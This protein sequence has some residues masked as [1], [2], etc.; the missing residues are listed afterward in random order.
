MKISG[1]TF[2]K[3]GNILGYPFRESILS[4]LPLV[5][6]FIVNVGESE[7]DT[8]E[9]VLA[10]Q[11]EHPKIK[12]LTSSWCE[13]MISKGYVYGQQKMIAQFQCSG[14][15]A[16]YLEADE[17]LHEEDLERIKS[18]MEAYLNDPEVEAL[19]FSY[20]HFYGNAHTYASSPAWYRSEV[21]A[22]KT[23]VRSYAPDGLFW[24]VLDESNKKGRYPQAVLINATIYH[25][26]WVRSE[27][28]M[29]LKHSKVAKYWKHR[30]NT[31]HY[32]EIDSQVLHLFNGTHPQ[33]AHK[34][35]EENTDHFSVHQL[36]EANPRHKLT[37]REKRHRILMKFEKLFGCDF[38][39]KHY[40]AIKKSPIQICCHKKQCCCS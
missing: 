9:Q 1:F 10:L 11:K 28:K 22:I 16:F 17:V 30:P 26:G 34:W 39:L 24:V 35:L 40:R 29:T 21:R 25:Y 13:K 7:D 36:F 3:N 23:S 27:E 31:Y 8:L 38:S 4:I 32:R 19:A 6:E 37:S 12:V 20:R 15:W 5:D 18:A 2:L 33:V 14:D